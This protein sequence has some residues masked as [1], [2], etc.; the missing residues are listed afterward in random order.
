MVR[1]FSALSVF[2]LLWN[3]SFSQS[4]SY[5]LTIEIEPSCIVNLGNDSIQHG[6]LLLYKSTS[7]E[8]FYKKDS[9]VWDLVPTNES[10]RIDSLERWTYLIEYTPSDTSILPSQ[11]V[12]QLNRDTKIYLDCYFFNLN[13]KPFS[14]NLESGEF[15]IFYSPSYP[16]PFSIKTGNEIVAFKWIVIQRVKRKHYAYYYEGTTPERGYGYGVGLNTNYPISLLFGANPIKI[17][18]KKEDLLQIASF[19]SSLTKNWF[20]IVT[21]HDQS[22]CK[23]NKSS[24]MKNDNHFSVQVDENLILELKEK[25]WQ[26]Q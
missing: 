19:E 4:N 16:N 7:F 1:K 12:I 9:A 3:L 2:V 14:S 5:S 20:E 10:Q 11:R 17:E 18:L 8:A 6:T 15:I 24:Y 25:L 23:I 22:V 26:N 13:F 21:A